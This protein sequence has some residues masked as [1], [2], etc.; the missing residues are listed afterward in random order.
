MK[1]LLKVPVKNEKMFQYRVPIILS[2]I[3]SLPF[4]SSSLAAVIQICRSVGMCS[5]AYRTVT[6]TTDKEMSSIFAD[7]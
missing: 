2:I 3:F 7:Q 4:A 6:V 1:K 5:L